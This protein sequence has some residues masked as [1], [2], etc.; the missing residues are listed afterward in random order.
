MKN[1]VPGTVCNKL[2]FLEIWFHFSITEIVS[3]SFP[4]NKESN[5]LQAC[6]LHISRYK[7]VTE[8]SSYKHTMICINLSC[9][10]DLCL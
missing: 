6:L 10:L 5:I 1:V 3:Q 8:N 7:S 9:F 2:M 4:Q